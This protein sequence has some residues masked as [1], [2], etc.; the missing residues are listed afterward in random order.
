AFLFRSH[1]ADIIRRHLV[2][3]EFFQHLEHLFGKFYVLARILIIF[4]ARFHIVYY[5]MQQH[6]LAAVAQSLTAAVADLI[7]NM[8][9][10][11]LE[12][13]DAR[14]QTADD[15][16]IRP[17]GDDTFIL[18]CILYRCDDINIRTQRLIHRNRFYLPEHLIGFTRSADPGPYIDAHRPTPF[19]L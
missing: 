4:E 15:I 6:H 11:A 12:A 10:E 9:D 17:G 16:F 7:E 8:P 1:E 3:P 2:C 5:F 14:P 13:E 18:Q 19:H